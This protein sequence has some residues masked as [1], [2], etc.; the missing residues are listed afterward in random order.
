MKRQK[1]IRLPEF[2]DEDDMNKLEVGDFFLYGNNVKGQ[3]QNKKDG[4]E[5]CYYEVIRKSNMGIEYAPVF[6]VLEK[7]EKGEEE[8]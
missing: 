5:I 1:F 6:D 4:E 7:T 2:E 3:K 8:L